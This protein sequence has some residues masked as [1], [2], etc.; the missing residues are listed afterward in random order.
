M[1]LTAIEKGTLT[2]RAGLTKVYSDEQSY[3]SGH[4]HAYERYGV[5]PNE[6]A[7]I[8]VRPDHCKFELGDLR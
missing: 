8:V 1:P 4:G 6:G 5:N 2:S 7:L 3:N